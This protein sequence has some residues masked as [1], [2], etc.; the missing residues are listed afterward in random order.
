L[1]AIAFGEPASA[2]AWKTKPAWGIV[3]SADHTINPDVERFGYKRAGFRAVVEIDGPH[4]VMQ[5]HPDD[6]V[7]VIT[8]A[9]AHSA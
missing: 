2:A 8:D 6:V 7:A 4:L 5:T 3:S 9:I 1:S